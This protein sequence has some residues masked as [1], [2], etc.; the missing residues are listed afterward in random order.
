MLIKGGNGPEEELAISEGNKRKVQHQEEEKYGGETGE[1][2][3]KEEHQNRSKRKAGV[4]FG[5][6]P[7]SDV[8]WNAELEKEVDGGKAGVH[9][10]GF[11]LK[12]P[13]RRVLRMVGGRIGKT[14]KRGNRTTKEKDWNTLPDIWMTLGKQVQSCI[15]CFSKLFDLFVCLLPSQRSSGQCR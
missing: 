13:K 8:L 12:N 6:T 3:G 10:N 2:E 14:D 5:L 11:E 7:S 1:N 9:K 4:F 15:S